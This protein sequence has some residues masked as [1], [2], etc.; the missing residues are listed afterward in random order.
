MSTAP[1]PREILDAESARSRFDA[2]LGDVVDGRIDAV[3]GF[4]EAIGRGLGGGRVTLLLDG[5]GLLGTLDRCA[6]ARL[7]NV[8]LVVRVADARG[9]ASSAAA[10]AGCA[11]LAARDLQDAIDLALVARRTA[12]AALQPVIVLDDLDAACVQD[13]AIPTREQIGRCIG[14]A[15][16]E[17]D[18][19]TP[20]QRLVFGERR[21]R[22]PRWF[23]L[24][25]PVAIGAVAD[26]VPDDVGAASQAAYVDDPLP[27][28]LEESFAVV[29]RA[30]DRAL[31]PIAVQDFAGARVALVAIGS[32]AGLAEDLAECERSARRLALCAVTVRALAPFPSGALSG[33]LR[34][35]RAVIVVERGAS[36][37]APALCAALPDAAA[38]VHVAIAGASSRSLRAADLAAFCRE[39]DGGRG[40]SRVWL[41]VDFAPRTRQF[42]KQQAL[43]DRLRRDVPELVARGLRTAATEDV[44]PRGAI[45]LE[46][47]RD[48]QQLAAV[49]LFACVGGAV[50]GVVHGAR[51]CVTAGADVHSGNACARP[52]AS[53]PRDAGLSAEQR[54]GTTFAALA[55]ARP[56]FDLE[57]AVEAF[58]RMVR[59]EPRVHALREAIRA[60]SGDATPRQPEVATD[61]GPVRHA[62]R[63]VG[64]SDAYDNLP[65]FTEHVGILAQRDALDELAPEPYLALRAVPPLS[66][67]AQRPGA[68]HA[69]IPALDPSRCTACGACWTACPDGALAPLAI[70][71]R[72]FLEAALDLGK[73]A[74]AATDGLRRYAGKL[75]QAIPLGANPSAGDAL[76][77]ACA[78]VVPPAA[79]DAAAIDA[80]AGAVG[81]LPIVASSDAF[82]GELTTL[83][84]EPDACKACGVCVAVCEP[85]AVEMTVRTTAR[86]AAARAGFAAWESLPDTPDATIRR[87]LSAGRPGHAATLGLSRHALLPLCGGDGAEPG[88][89]PRLAVRLVLGA[90]EAHRQPLLARSRDEIEVLRE[91][92]ASR[93]HETLARALPSADLD[94]LADGLHALGR[95][96]VALADLAARVEAARG[97]GQVDARALDS[98]IAAA[99]ELADRRWRLERGVQGFGRARAGLLV[100]PAP[101]L[102]WALAFPANPFAMPVASGSLSLARGLVAAQTD[103]WLDD[104]RLTRR[105]SLLLDRP[106]EAEHATQ[107]LAALRLADLEA[108]DRA[109]CPPLVC[110]ATARSLA[111]Q[112]LADLVALLCGDL[113]LLIVAVV[114]DA[115]SSAEL[116]LLA[117]AA[118]EGFV[119]QTSIGAPDHLVRAV[120]RALHVQRPALL[121]VHAPSPVRDGFAPRDLVARAQAAI[122]SHAFPLF[123]SDPGASPSLGL[124]LDLDGNPGDDGVAPR[125]AA[126]TA[127]R[128]LAGADTPWS[129]RVR[130]EAQRASE[131]SR[132]TELE[133]ARAGAKDELLAR[134]TVR[135]GDLAA[136]GRR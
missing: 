19:S 42:P 58:R 43:F 40:R 45:T 119:A 52:D 127:L 86:V 93:I 130:E 17:I 99:K 59:A 14:V 84:L 128:E 41:G 24:D 79:A 91:R 132:A 28:L 121:C 2:S 65:R 15:S 81:A 107:K 89:G 118:R 63:Q 68:A 5:E 18:G 36:R 48:E 31:A 26:G 95:G 123:T 70:P 33:A 66:A 134:L 50:R 126:W 62:L 106:A 74:G 61:A 4:D 16:D 7:Q 104:L 54:L 120:T 27:A 78:A 6:R 85:K 71:P 60:A 94:A 124:R 76:R 10:N 11:V 75:A 25:R 35:P 131:A 29:A 72:A 20:A 83:A 53:A 82:S 87:C 23:D 117:L 77:A 114:D 1:V 9:L 30:L 32:A 100:V 92:L 3:R 73:R 105:A 116:G 67:N 90:V 88:S 102:D 8:P 22:V 34:G 122:A 37:L 135:L 133:A 112:G 57:A 129:A 46:V 51:A 115:S 69:T 98:L 47:A 49:M 13:V 110:F 125:P 108:K 136:R 55:R 109:A 103:A 113:P 44:R 39:V 97:G 96:D 101:E 21:R 64:A 12:E 80:M 111:A 38:R 56:G